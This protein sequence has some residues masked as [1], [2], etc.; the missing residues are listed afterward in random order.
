M[1]AD[2]LMLIT[3]PAATEAFEAVVIA[4]TKPSATRAELASCCVLPTTFCTG[5][6]FDSDT[7]K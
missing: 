6:A 7:L 3:K 5:T 4:T 1:P 2:G